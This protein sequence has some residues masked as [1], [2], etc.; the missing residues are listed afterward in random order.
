MLQRLK[1]WLGGDDAPDLTELFV[2]QYNL[3]IDGGMAHEKAVT[4]IQQFYAWTDQELATALDGVEFGGDD[5]LDTI[6]KRAVTGEGGK[7][8][9]FDWKA[10]GKHPDQYPHLGIL[11]SSGSGKTAL[12][13]W[14]LHLLPGQPTVI[15]TKRRPQQWRGLPVTGTP[16]DFPKIE[17]TLK[18]LVTLMGE[19]TA[20]LETMEGRDFEPLNVAIDEYPAINAN[21]KETPRYI[22]TLLREARETRIRLLILLQG[23][24]VKTLGLE[25]QSD[26]RDCIT[27]IR[28][29]SFAVK[30]ADKVCD[31]AVADWVQQQR[32]PCMVDDTPAFIP[33][34]SQWQP[35]QVWETVGNQGNP[36][37]SEDQE[38]GNPVTGNPESALFL[39]LHQLIEATSY[40]HVVKDLMGCEGRNYQQGKQ[41]LETLLSR[42]Q[43]GV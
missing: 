39:A 38:P 18:E 24:Q 28:L 19:R 29:G 33:D 40:S 4:A 22:T 36:S 34:L 20:E 15:T 41:I 25:G 13:E 2:S 14:L 12:T 35:G 37:P 42:L 23:Q 27:F 10:L 30:H 16:R 6:P 9:L 1:Q 17:E 31:T 11:G 32:Y 43:Q 3:L 7:F 8:P 26:L 21:I 5:L